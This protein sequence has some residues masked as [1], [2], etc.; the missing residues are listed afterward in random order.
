[1]KLL[2]TQSDSSVASLL[3]NDKNNKLEDK[4]ISRPYL[5]ILSE[6]SSEEAL[7]LRFVNKIVLLQ[8]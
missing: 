7:S 4:A 8:R 5:V 3:Q 6:S 1:M 2:K